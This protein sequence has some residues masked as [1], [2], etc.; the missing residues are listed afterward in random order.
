[1]SLPDWTTVETWKYQ[2][3]FQNLGVKEIGAMA[4][5]LLY[6]FFDASINAH[7]T[8]ASRKTDIVGIGD[9]A[10]AAWINWIENAHDMF[11][12]YTGNQGGITDEQ[13]IEF[14]LLRSMF[15]G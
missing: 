10:A 5:C 7:V 11:V 14:E 1:M 15:G 3:L 8:Q 4:D 2:K 6:T 12:F 13:K 9:T